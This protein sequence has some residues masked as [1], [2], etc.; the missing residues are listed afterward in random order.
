M[1]NL[2][3]VLNMARQDCY[4]ASIDLGNAYFTLPTYTTHEPKMLAI[5]IRGKFI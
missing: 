5:S 4:M 1:N 3:T 2:S